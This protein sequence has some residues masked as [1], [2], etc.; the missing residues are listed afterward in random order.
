MQNN[1]LEGLRR[2]LRDVQRML[3]GDTS[4][5]RIHSPTEIA[6]NKEHSPH[7]ASDSVAGATLRFHDRGDRMV[8]E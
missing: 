4:A 3:A 5:G 2:G 6:K 1:A 7:Y 8:R